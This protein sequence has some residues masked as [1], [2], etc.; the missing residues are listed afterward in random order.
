[1]TVFDFIEDHSLLNPENVALADGIECITY[2]ELYQLLAQGQKLF[3]DKGLQDGDIVGI[4][5]CNRLEWVI[6]FLCLMSVKCWVVPLPP[7]AAEREVDEIAALVNLKCI[8]DSMNFRHIP[9]MFPEKCKL[10]KP[11]GSETG[12]YHATSGSTGK[13]KLCVRPLQRLTME[14]ISYMKTLNIQDNDR[15]LCLPPVYHSYCLGAGCMASLV[16]GSCLYLLDRFIPRNA[17]RIIENEGITILLLVPVMAKAMCYLYGEEKKV[18]KQLRIALVGTGSIT[19]DVYIGFLNQYGVPLL[20]N[21]GSTETGGIISRLTPTPRDSIGK[22]MYGVDIRITDDNG[23]PVQVDCEGELMVKCDG[24]MTGYLNEKEEINQDGFFAMGD[25]VLQDSDGYLYV[26][27]RKKNIINIGGKKVNPFEIEMVLSGY[28]GVKE[29]AVVGFFK[30]NGEE[31]IKA[32]IAGKDLNEH[33]I[34]RYCQSQLSSHKI[35]SIIEFC[36]ALPR[37]ELGKI[38]REALQ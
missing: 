6:A 31:G 30:S 38:R 37:N 8:I 3:I 1:M 15:I 32:V 2:K 23:K 21:Y 20:S 9:D 17:V 24:M 28:P 5:I 12:V 18:M 14:G 26:K 11:S 36:E 35:P 7:D 29:C 34:R 4:K 19:E 16:S 22:P 33:D 27:G 25:I 10:I 13:P